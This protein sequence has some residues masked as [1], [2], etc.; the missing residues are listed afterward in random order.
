[1]MLLRQ[2]TTRSEETCEC[3]FACRCAESYWPTTKCT[4]IF[5]IKPMFRHKVANDC[6]PMTLAVANGE[7]EEQALSHQQFTEANTKLKTVTK[8]I[9]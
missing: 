7:Q 6:A 9:N 2:R 3:L 8:R 5:Q 1:M 4:I